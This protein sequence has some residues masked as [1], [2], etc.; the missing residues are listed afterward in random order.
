MSNKSLLDDNNKIP[1]II[2]S[3]DINELIQNED[4]IKK[5]N[6]EL[7]NSLCQK[8]YLMNCNPEYCTYRYTNTCDYL[9]ALKYI[10]DEY[11]I[12]LIKYC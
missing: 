7:F 11:N 5:L 3:I 2:E 1:Q 10:L 12:N 4:K 6:N 9:K 8:G